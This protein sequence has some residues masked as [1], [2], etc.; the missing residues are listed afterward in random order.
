MVIVCESKTSA[1]T[2]C[3]L[4]LGE[5]G[6]TFWATLIRPTSARTALSISC[7]TSGL[8]SSS[9]ARLLGTGFLLS[10]AHYPGCKNRSVIRCHDHHL[11]DPFPPS[12]NRRSMPPLG[13][14]R[15]CC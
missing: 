15:L 6:K 3:P 8:H 12:K 11:L 4:G 2:Y 5:P 10:F 14:R 13:S 9:R 1:G 7:Q